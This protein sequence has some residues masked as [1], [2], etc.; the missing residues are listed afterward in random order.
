MRSIVLL[1]GWGMRPAVFARLAALRVARSAVHALPLPGHH[2]TPS[3]SPY[4]VDALAAVLADLAPPACSIVGWALGAQGALAWAR[5]RPEQVDRLV[6][7]SAT[8][9]FVQRCDWRPAMPVAVFEAFSRAV[10][11]GPAAAVRGF[12]KVQVQEDG[13]AG[14]RAV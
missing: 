10:R 9:C 7:M 11:E 8:P 3:P 12:V 13:A 2:E 4:D 5:T 6:L 1:H 14:R